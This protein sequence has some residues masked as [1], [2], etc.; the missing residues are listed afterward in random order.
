MAKLPTNCTMDTDCQGTNGIDIFLSTCTCG[1]NNAGTAFCK[2]FIG[3]QPGVN[4]ITTW[5]GAMKKTD[6]KCNTARRTTDQCLQRVGAYDDTLVA[7]WLYDNYPL[8]QGND[9]CVQAVL[10]SDYWVTPSGG[11]FIVLTGM[12]SLFF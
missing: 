8:I 3:D 6:K 12:F 1:Y 4:F 9:A 5:V 11:L 10:T 7:T 2:P